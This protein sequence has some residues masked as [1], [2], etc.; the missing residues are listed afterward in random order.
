MNK[1]RRMTCFGAGAAVLACVHCIAPFASGEE[2]SLDPNAL[3]TTLPRNGDVLTRHD[4][5]ETPDGLT[6]TVRGSAPAGAKALVNGACATGYAFTEH[7]CNPVFWSDGF[8]G[9]PSP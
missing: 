5:N 8:W 1:F 7:G 2:A 3:Q 4:S 9:I 6:I